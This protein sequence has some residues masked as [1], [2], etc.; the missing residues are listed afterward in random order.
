MKIVRTGIL[1][2]EAHDE[3]QERRFDSDYLRSL[4][5][6]QRFRMVI[7]TSTHIAQLLL[8]RGHRRAF[9]IVKRA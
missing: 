3:E 5:T 1:K 6:E 8:D 9:E 2:L 7:E 4:S